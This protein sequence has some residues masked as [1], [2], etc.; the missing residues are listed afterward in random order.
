MLRL[1]EWHQKTYLVGMSAYGGSTARN[2]TESLKLTVTWVRGNGCTISRLLVKILL[3]SSFV[4]C[5]VGMPASL[6]CTCMFRLA[7][8]I[9]T[10]AKDDRDRRMIMKTLANCSIQVRAPVECVSNVRQISSYLDY[11]WSSNQLRLIGLS[12]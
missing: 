12:F 1:G 9:A 2:P 6:T 3:A 4:K 11:P 5:S 10:Q 7:F 8:P